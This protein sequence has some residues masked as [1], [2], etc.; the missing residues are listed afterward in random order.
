MTAD[1]RA[2]WV[3]ATAADLA[4]VLEYPDVADQVAQILASADAD[5]PQGQ[6]RAP[7]VDH[8]PS[9]ALDANRGGRG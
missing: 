2:A 3:A 4:R 8:S 6:S 1:A 7:G 9:D 5:R